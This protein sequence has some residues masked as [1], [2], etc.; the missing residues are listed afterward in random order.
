MKHRL[1]ALDWMRGI[2]MVLMT[3]DHAS[4]AYNAGRIVTDSPFFY[5][6]DMSLPVLQFINRWVTHICAPTFLFLA[7]TSLALSIT[8]KE[9][10]GITPSSID[11]DLLVRGL[12]I[13]AV[14]I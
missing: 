14:D 12:I 5:N 3:I 2:V 1:P 11:H 10:K 7:G 8:R 4:G 9:R 6:P 13:V